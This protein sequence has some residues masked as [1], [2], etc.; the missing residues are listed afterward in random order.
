MKNRI[1]SGMEDDEEEEDKKD[2]NKIINKYESKLMIL[3]NNK[4]DVFNEKTHNNIIDN[5]NS[6]I[7]SQNSGRTKYTSKFSDKSGK[8]KNNNIKI[9]D[10]DLNKNISSSIANKSIKTYKTNKLNQNDIEIN[11][12]NNKINKFC[13]KTVEKNFNK[14]YALKNNEKAIFSLDKNIKTEKNNNSIY[15]TSFNMLFNPY[16]NNKFFYNKS[17]NI[18][19]MKNKSVSNIIKNIIN[20]EEKNLKKEKNI[21]NKKESNKLNNDDNYIKNKYT[22]YL[23]KLFKKKDIKESNN[24][25][26]KKNKNNKKIN[27]TL[28]RINNKKKCKCNSNSC[29]SLFRNILILLIISSAITFY[30]F[31][32]FVNK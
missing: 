27:Y 21:K 12:E 22:N 2:I 31:V 15:D 16:D 10:E 5:K 18:T 19:L 32:F 24:K 6:D 28:D 23:N 25:N 14:N 20:I 7:I 26:I 4:E 1:S 11:C 17:K 13:D 29:L 8:Y 30:A 9:F 3:K